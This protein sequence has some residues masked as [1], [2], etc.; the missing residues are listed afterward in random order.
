MS[1]KTFVPVPADSDFTVDNI[2]FAIAATVEDPVPRPVSAIGDDAIDLKVFAAAG[3]FNTPHLKD[4]AVRVFSERS[5]NAFMSLGRPAWRE[6][7]T[8]IQNLL[9][10]APGPL[11]DDA[12]LRAR[13]L[14]PLSKLRYH[15]PAEIGDYTDFYASKEH[16]T[17][18]GTMFRGKDNALMPN[19]VHLPVGYHG[20][21]SSVVVSGTPIK[22]PSGLILN[23]AT[24]SPEFGVSKKLDFE[25][26]MA[27]LVG[28]GNKL[29]EPVDI[30]KAE[31]HIFGLVL[32][33]DWS[34]RDIQQ[35]EYVPLGP[36]LG[37]NFGTTISPWVITLE[38]LESFRVPQPEQDPK[39]A[40]YLQSGP[41]DAYDIRL[42]VYVKR[43]LLELSHNGTQPIEVGGGQKRGFLEN[44]DEVIMRGVCEG[45]GPDGRNVRIG[46]GEAAGLVV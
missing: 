34:A 35:F 2:P 33:N 27:F 25:L 21:A 29:G 12:A 32:M 23:P 39:P 41:R 40:A 20:R 36:F 15:L 45:V 43:S 28:P 8:T 24:K 13:A 38:A 14:I 7:R 19:W 4:H 31:D 26:E 6:A 11:R 42:D 46:F 22:R 44:G 10:D 5:L 37:K 3:L 9:S 1:S 16:A 18:V 17:N 30:A